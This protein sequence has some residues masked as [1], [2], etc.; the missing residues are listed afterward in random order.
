MR[1]R[2]FLV[3]GALTVAAT[4][5][6]PGI[7]S[8]TVSN[9]TITPTMTPT[10]LA[11]KGDPTPVSLMVNTRADYSAPGTDP[12][13]TQV[14]VDLPS[15][16]KINT[17]GQK[18]CPATQLAQTTTSQALSECPG[19]QLS[20]TPGSANLNGV[21]GAQTG[22][23]TAFLGGPSTILLHVRVDALSIT[24]ILTGEIVDSPLGGVYG[25]RLA[26]SIP[27]Q[28]VGGGHEI[29][30]NFTT[31]IDKKFT[32]KKKKKGKKVK[33]KSGII[34]STCK[35]R[36]LSFQGTFLFTQFPATGIPG[37]T[38][39]TFA[40]TATVACTPAKPKK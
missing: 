38:G 19:A 28:Q 37:G 8:A 22:V 25:K 34:T 12:A 2:K 31:I 3:A 6:A 10:K 4:V 5:A 35:D 21:V 30:T 39:P 24:Q 32:V 40:P 36:T 16:I 15:E 1:K 9:Q 13:A 26:V 11:K 14:N 23:V 7:A 29:L 33:V 18:T 17:K 20:N 27:A